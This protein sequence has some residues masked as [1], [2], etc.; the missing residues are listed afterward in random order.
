[1]IQTIRDQM[2]ITLM[3]WCNKPKLKCQNV[4]H[5]MKVVIQEILKGKVKQ[6]KT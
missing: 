1:M 4:K 2:E 5:K 6:K 3:T